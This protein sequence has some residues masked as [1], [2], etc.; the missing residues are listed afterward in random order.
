MNKELREAVELFISQPMNNMLSRSQI[1]D[2]AR[3]ALP[4][5]EQQERVNDDWIVWAGGNCPI[6]KNKVV[7]VKFRDGDT[8]NN[9]AKAGTMDWFHFGDAWDIIAYRLVKP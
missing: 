4:L 2:V 7:Y 6:D 9:G 8:D 3:I 5:L 1:M